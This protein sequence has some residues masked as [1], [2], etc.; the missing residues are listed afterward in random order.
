MQKEYQTHFAY[1]LLAPNVF[2]ML[3]IV[4]LQLH[5]FCVFCVVFFN[6]PFGVPEL[7]C[8]YLLTY[9]LHKL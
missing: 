9:F 4:L 8:T 3:L 5:V 7:K 1:R 2:N 6:G